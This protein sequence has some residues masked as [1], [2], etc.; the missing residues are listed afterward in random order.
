MAR[1]D[2][3]SAVTIGS[4]CSLQSYAPMIGHQA[5]KEPQL[6]Q[7]SPVI[8]DR[9]SPGYPSRSAGSSSC[10]LNEW[11]HSKLP[12]L[13]DRQSSLMHVACSHADA[14]SEQTDKGVN[15]TTHIMHLPSPSP[16]SIVNSV[17]DRVRDHGGEHS[18]WK[19]SWPLQA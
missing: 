15:F 12:G 8:I 19:R 16:T 18:T 17:R 9:Q 13:S 5:A 4:P 10:R 3:H 2:V 6:A 14:E 1:H 7:L 11:Q